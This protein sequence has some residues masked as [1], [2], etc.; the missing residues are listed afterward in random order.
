MKVCAKCLELISKLQSKA[1]QVKQCS[2]Y[3]AVTG[4]IY[5]LKEQF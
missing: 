2:P 4:K 1:S 3:Q 5:C